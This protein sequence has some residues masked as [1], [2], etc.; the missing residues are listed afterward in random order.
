MQTYESLPINRH[1]AYR[2]MLLAK[3][4]GGNVVEEDNGNNDVMTLHPSGFS[5]ETSSPTYYHID[6]GSEAG[7]AYGPGPANSS[8][9]SEEYDDFAERTLND[10]GSRRRMPHFRDLA[11]ATYHQNP[12]DDGTVGPAAGRELSRTLAEMDVIP[13]DIHVINDAEA[14]FRQI[15]ASESNILDELLRRRDRSV[16]RSR[17]RAAPGV[18]VI[19]SDED[20]GGD[21]VPVETVWL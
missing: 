2:E 8:N 1:G 14:A 13:N 9:V 12:D 21:A 17:R 19:E 16:R 11:H 5:F 3:P 18:N 15:Y 4:R 7:V 10:F 20:D 6:R